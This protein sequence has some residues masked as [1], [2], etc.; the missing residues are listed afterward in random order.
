MQDNKST[1]S[2]ANLVNGNTLVTNG[3]SGALDLLRQENGT[4]FFA[5][6]PG[7]TQPERIQRAI[8]AAFVPT[9]HQILADQPITLHNLQKTPDYPAYRTQFLESLRRNRIASAQ[10]EKY[11]LTIPWPLDQIGA[12]AVYDQLTSTP[13]GKQILAI[14]TGHNSEN[15]QDV[16]A[17]DLEK[18]LEA[19]HRNLPDYRTPVAF[20]DLRRRFLLDIKSQASPSQ[21]DKYITSM[22]TY[23][24]QL[25][26]TRYEYY[27]EFQ[28]LRREA[29]NLVE[30][31][32]TLSA[33]TAPTSDGVAQTADQALAP[34]LKGVR[35]S[36]VSD[37]H[38]EQLISHA[39]IEGDLWRQAG[40]DYRL[41]I[42]SL[43]NAGLVPK[44][45]VACDNQT[46]YL[47]NL[48]QLTSEQMAALAYVPS[49][50]DVKVRAYYRDKST[51][52][53]RYL[54]DYIRDI[55][56]EGIAI[57][58][59]GHDAHSVTLPIILQ[60]ALNQ[61]ERNRGIIDLSSTNPDFLFAGTAPSYA[62]RQEYRDAYAKGLLRG[63]FYREVSA[64]AY[65]ADAA[66]LIRPGRRKNAPQLISMPTDAMPNF[67]QPIAHY[68]VYSTLTG[69][70]MGEGFPAEN[71][72]SSWL[73]YSD[74]RGRCWVA[75]QETN[76][77]VTSTGCRK[78]WLLPSD[79][80]TPLYESTL[81][82]DS[83]GDPGDVRDGNLVSM[84]NNYLSKI[85]LISTYA[86]RIAAA[87]S[88]QPQKSE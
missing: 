71:R 79:I 20:A 11:L 75:H 5:E 55:S 81:L 86:A 41:G 9:I 70:T 47:T 36:P 12:R 46:V 14:V 4:Y 60:S 61:I 27:R 57:F 26:G 83:Y 82:A 68:S 13:R 77:P 64:G 45:E 88:G 59:T 62:T 25:Y 6:I 49:G 50:S 37:E 1:I 3:D 38:R 10:E 48:F 87:Q 30:S 43:V 7:L 17:A 28:N 84:W 74:Y 33:E 72:Q 40:Q 58:G 35:L 29:Q 73:F 76:A 44:Y 42:P 34:S 51:A 18:F 63:D 80:A 24:E 52:L 56:G 23:E 85:P 65:N 19:P 67:N 16:V 22:N 69:Q 31:V 8:I 66:N 15:W 21:L 78:E 39:I 32:A 54:P 53:W 2:Q